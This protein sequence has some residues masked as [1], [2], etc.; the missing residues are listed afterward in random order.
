MA[1]AVVDPGNASSFVRRM[2]PTAIAIISIRLRYF[3]LVNLVVG[4]LLL[5]AGGLALVVDWYDS[6]LPIVVELSAPADN[7]ESAEIQTLVLTLTNNGTHAI[8][9]IG[10]EERLC[11]EN[12]CFQITPPAA[13]HATLEPGEKIELGA[14]AHRRTKSKGA[15]TGLGAV[16]YVNYRGEL[17]EMHIPVTVRW[18]Q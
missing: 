17:R 7:L 14:L 18:D 2:H 4:L 10:F 1:S 12:F 3:F 11:G 15:F 8:T 13:G 5:A 9:I 6:R 16:L